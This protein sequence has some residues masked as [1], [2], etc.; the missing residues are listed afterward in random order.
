MPVEVEVECATGKERELMN[1]VR[2]HL[3]RHG[4]QIKG[5]RIQFDK[6]IIGLAIGGL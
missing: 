5:F 6:N 4:F 3:D 1:T 2:L